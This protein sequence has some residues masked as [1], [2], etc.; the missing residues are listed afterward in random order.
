MIPYPSWEANTIGSDTI[1]GSLADNNAT[2]ISPLR[3]SVDECDRLWVMDTGLYDIY[4]SSKQIAAPALVIFDLNTDKLIKRYTLP[5]SVIIGDP[6]FPS[7]VS[8]FLSVNI[9]ISIS[10]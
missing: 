5:P 4:G 8:F 1:E 6:F 7:V 2:V 9:S 10:K 3:I